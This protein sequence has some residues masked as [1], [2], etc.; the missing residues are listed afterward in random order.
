MRSIILSLTVVCL[1]LP[2]SVIR[3]QPTDNPKK[4]KVASPKEKAL[5]ADAAAREELL[6]RRA[7]DK[8]REQAERLSLENL[9]AQALK[10]NPDIRVAESKLR[11]AEAELN[12]VKLQVTQK[13]VA[14]RREIA[15][16]QA[17]LTAAQA[18]FARVQQL[19]K[20]G[21]AAQEIV[22]SAEAKLQKAKAELART[23]GEMPYTL[24][25]L[26][27]VWYR[28][29]LEATYRQ[30]V[31]DANRLGGGFT[32][33]KSWST[34]T[35]TSKKD[36][37]QRLRDQALAAEQARLIELELDRALL[38]KQAKKAR[39]AIPPAMADKLRKALDT[40]VKL[41]FTKVGPK[42]LL[43][44]LE[45]HGPGFNLVV[46]Q[47]L[48]DNSSPINLKLTEPVPIGAVFQLL[49]DQFGWRFVVREYGIVV[50][51]AGRVPPGAISLHEFWK[52]RPAQKK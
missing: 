33:P 7:E 16:L 3:S 6:L 35:T 38:E 21:A 30:A 15:V 45:D 28:N 27:G 39:P 5:A 43:E 31:G 4:T 25:S 11:E 29:A 51:R 48:L 10:N 37:A 18:D 9:L 46:D 12:R 22:Q 1:L 41:E 36:D 19:Y 14:L 44:F 52:N 24:G 23:E 32:K 47:P 26:S 2:A 8:L 50:S 20:T 49:E 17:A 42:E 40:P 34:K 13:V